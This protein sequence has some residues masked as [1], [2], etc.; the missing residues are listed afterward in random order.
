MRTELS[1]IQRLL[2][3]E[4]RSLPLV[5]DMVGKNADRLLRFGPLF[6]L[7]SRKSDGKE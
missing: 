7:G 1:K 3:I 6:G 2:G 5:W 4:K